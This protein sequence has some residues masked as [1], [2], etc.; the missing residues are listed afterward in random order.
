V[1]DDTEAKII[2]DYEK[3]KAKI[4]GGLDEY[5]SPEFINRIDRVVVFNPLDKTILKKIIILQLD[6][7]QARLTDLGVKLAY[8][9]KALNLILKETYNPEF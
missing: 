2:R 1:S 5:F 6:R 9:T 7:L 3:I 4:V 8:D